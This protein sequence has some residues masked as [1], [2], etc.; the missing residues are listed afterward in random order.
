M[1][2]WFC[3]G[4]I[5]AQ[6]DS[7]RGKS[8]VCPEPPH[9]QHQHQHQQQR[10]HRRQSGCCPSPRYLRG[11]LPYSTHQPAALATLALATPSKEIS[12]LSYSRAP[13]PW[14]G[15]P[16]PWSPQSGL[17]PFQTT[18]LHRLRRCWAR[19]ELGL[20]SSQ[21]LYKSARQWMQVGCLHL[22]RPLFIM[23]LS[24]LLLILIIILSDV[25]SHR[26]SI[27]SH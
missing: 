8:P 10:Q 11:L 13:L 5:F 14:T 23:I 25:P 12:N 6:S 7:G 4:L 22:L 9:Q 21:S 18:R 17:A 26:F 15:P 3:L 2:L 24:L 19:A 16:T 1:G 27:L 20:G